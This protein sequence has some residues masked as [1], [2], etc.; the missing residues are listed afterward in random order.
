[1]SS[2]KRWALALAVALTFAATVS[3]LRMVRSSILPVRH[4]GGD[5]LDAE[6]VR[7]YL[8]AQAKAFKGDV[9]GAH[10][11]YDMEHLLTEG[12]DFKDV[13]WRDVQVAEP[14]IDELHDRYSLAEILQALRPA[15]QG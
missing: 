9:V 2:S 11:A 12:I 8:Q 1:M 4:Q 7:N 3:L 13:K 15:G 10:L 5:N 6:Q 14:L